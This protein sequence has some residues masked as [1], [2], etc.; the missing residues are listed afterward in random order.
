MKFSKI[1]PILGLLAVLC[2]ATRADDLILADGRFIANVKVS[3]TEGGYT[4]HYKNGD[5]FV[6]ED[7]VKTCY[8]VDSS[9]A[10]VP[11]TDEEKAKAEK[12]LVPFEGKWVTT[13]KRDAVI[14]KR[15]KEMEAKFKELKEH[16]LWRNR[17]ITKTKNFQFEYTLDQDIFQGYIDLMETYYKTFTK[18]WKIKKPTKLGP[19]TVC[20]YHDYDT[21]LQVSGT[22]RGVQGYY[23]FRPLTQLELNFYYNR[24]D[25]EYTTEVM[26]HEAN[27][28]L[29]HLIDLDFRY[30]H[31]INEGM[32]EYYGATKWDPKKKKMKV[33]G[34]LEGRLTE[35]KTDIEGGDFMRLEDYLRNE[36]GYKDY[37]W[38][39]T[40]VHMMMETPRYAK[41]FKRFFIGLAKDKS[42]KRRNNTITGDDLLEYFKLKMKLR[43]IDA[44]E[45]EWHDY[46][47]QD[48]KLTSHRGYEQAAK[49]LERTGQGRKAK[50]FYK[51]A[52]EAGSKNPRVYISYAR[53]LD[54]KNEAIELMKKA[55][56]FA[57]LTA[58]VWAQMG[59]YMRNR[60][61]KESKKE[62][63]RL[64]RLAVEMDPNDS[65]VRF[66]ARS[67]EI[68][69]EAD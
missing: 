3:K 36:L 5:V 55:T 12:G 62:G 41:K 2:G 27:H 13:A 28:Y 43:D 67:A 15:R 64:L 50:R 14:K 9:G 24:L 4:V 63:E 10:F 60:D 19:L 25:P 69:L 66:A 46:I 61:D 23:R 57:P 37:T 29:T 34:I 68:D 65:A 26:F 11:T 42:A 39:W 20:F 21:F 16:E 30:P 51:K 18:Q 54:D 33:G 17:Y 31:C 8:S 38:G 40:F 44:L 47:Q 53:M 7:M 56:T 48:L 58:R 52:I 49:S 59:R 6:P 1:L 45:K 22:S 32:A 35:V